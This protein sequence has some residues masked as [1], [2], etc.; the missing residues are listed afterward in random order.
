M[1]V[2]Y[3]Y[4][5]YYTLFIRAKVGEPIMSVATDAIRVGQFKS[6]SRSSSA[7][8]IEESIVMTASELEVEKREFVKHMG[9]KPATPGLPA[10]QRLLISH[11]VANSLSCM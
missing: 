7:A 5:L 10:P 11:S 3:V 4:L 8:R 2:L 6:A 1:Y 9:F